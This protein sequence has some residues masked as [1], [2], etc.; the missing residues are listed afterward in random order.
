MRNLKL[1]KRPNQLYSSKNIY[2]LETIEEDETNDSNSPIESLKD[3]ET[4]NLIRELK[5]AKQNFCR[6]K[7]FDMIGPMGVLGELEVS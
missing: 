7:G 3:R 4:I 1:S 6:Q 5:W 2:V